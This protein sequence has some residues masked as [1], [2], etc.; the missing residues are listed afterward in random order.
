VE[1][2]A[3]VSLASLLLLKR[4]QW[5]A[6]HLG[7]G[8]IL[9]VG[10]ALTQTLPMVL[11]GSIDRYHLAVVATLLPLVAARFTAAEP[12]LATV[13]PAAAILF[14]SVAVY[15]VGAADLDTWHRARHLAAAKAYALGA[16]RGLGPEAVE[17]GYE[18]DVTNYLIPYFEQ[19]GKA[20]AY[21]PGGLMSPSVR[22]VFAGPSDPRPGASYGGLAPGRV[23]I[24]A[25]RGPRASRLPMDPKNP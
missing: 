21:G 2:A 22:L 24:E 8:G 25:E 4:R 5:A 10:I 17:A 1:L 9:L 13:L 12:R 19:T 14:A 11:T 16:G 20:P 15:V 3:V 7:A 23:V 18:E 6:S